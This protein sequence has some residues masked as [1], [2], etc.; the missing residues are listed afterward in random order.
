ML[1]LSS[2][3]YARFSPVPGETAANARAVP[4][5]GVVP[6]LKPD[7]K[8]A[9]IRYESISNYMAPMPMPFN[10]KTYGEPA[11]LQDSDEIPFQVHIT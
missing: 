3:R 4:A 2:V 9:V 10:V 1:N 11:G 6:K 8:T 5:K 7:K